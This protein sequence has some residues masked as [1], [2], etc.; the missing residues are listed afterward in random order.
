[1]DQRPFSAVFV[2]DRGQFVWVDCD[3][4]LGREQAGRRPALVLSPANYNRPSQLFLVCPV[5]TQRKGYPFEVAIPDG[6]D[7]TGVI[8]CDQLKSLD[9]K[10]RKAVL[11]CKCPDDVIAE[12]LAKLKPLLFTQF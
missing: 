2:P 1:M 7:V 12:V 11:I 8:I 6:L 10:Q 5:T 4:Q 9:F 3:P